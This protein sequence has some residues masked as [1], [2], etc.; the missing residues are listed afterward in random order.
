MTLLL[1]HPSK[2]PH[3]DSVAIQVCAGNLD[4]HL[5]AVVADLPDSPGRFRCA[6]DH[7]VAHLWDALL[8]FLG[9]KLIPQLLPLRRLWDLIRAAASRATFVL[10]VKVKGFRDRYFGSAGGAGFGEGPWLIFQAHALH[11]GILG[12][13][14]VEVQIG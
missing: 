6:G 2:V 12:G 3:R 1:L 10:P 5:G 4:V 7:V 9:H 8:R 11:G 13:S 14:P